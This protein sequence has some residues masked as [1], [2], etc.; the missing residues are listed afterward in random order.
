MVRDASIAS[1]ALFHCIIE[2]RPNGTTWRFQEI[3]CAK[4]WCL[5][6]PIQS[7]YL[8]LTE[9]STH[10]AVRDESGRRVH[11]SRQYALLSIRLHFKCLQIS[12]EVPSLKKGRVDCSND[13]VAVM[14]LLL[15]VL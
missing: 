9:P 4:G 10:K 3:L 6:D 14:F 5:I 1:I 15:Y 11:W 13:M 8:P 12:F 2:A 7:P